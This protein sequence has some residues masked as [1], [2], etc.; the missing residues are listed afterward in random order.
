MNKKIIAFIVSSSFL[1]AS[2]I[3]APQDS[4]LERKNVPAKAILDPLSYPATYVADSSNSFRD[5][6]SL[7]CDVPNLKEGE[8]FDCG[9]TIYQSS[10][11]ME[12]SLRIISSKLTD[13]EI[14]FSSY[15]SKIKITLT[16][17]RKMAEYAAIYDGPLERAIKK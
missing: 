2:I 17:L 1:S 16:D 7:V 12:G 8:T 14:E 15:D 10:G 13:E 5:G 11:N 9:G 3:A 4:F 6:D